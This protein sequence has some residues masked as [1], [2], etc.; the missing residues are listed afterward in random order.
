MYEIQNLLNQFDDST[1]I[2]THKIIYHGVEGF[3]VYNNTSPFEIDGKTYIAGRIEKRDSEHSKIGFFLKEDESNYRLDVTTPLL[4]LQDPYISFINGELVIGGTEI[5]DHPTTP[6]ALWYK[7]VKYRGHDLNSLTRFFEGPN[8]MKD[9][10]IVELEN[11]K[12]LVFTRPQGEVGGRGKIG[13]LIIDSLEQLN[14]VDLVNAPLLDLF[15]EEE[16]GGANQALLL[17]NGKIGVLS[18]IAKFDDAGDRHYYAS[19]F[20]IDAT[21]K[22]VEN[23]KIISCREN[24]TPGPSK[25]PDLFDVVF[26]G[27]IL[28]KGDK[29]ELFVASSD[30][31]SHYVEMQNPFI[32]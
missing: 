19:T 32:G 17:E 12:I 16:W 9:I 29:A 1:I 13:T 27:G 22:E 10:R 24:L 31:E 3:D 18:H 25:R 26:P 2:K 11:Q 7:A 20:V 23:F 6:N 5:F 21:G 14:E 15:L 30:C 8:G 28:I 4:E